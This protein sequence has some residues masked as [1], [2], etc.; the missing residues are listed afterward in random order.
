MIHSPSLPTACAR[1]IRLAPLTIVTLMMTLT[2]K[3]S[4][5]MTVV[6]LMTVESI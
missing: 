6:T 1:T 4:A 2:I 3:K 5:K